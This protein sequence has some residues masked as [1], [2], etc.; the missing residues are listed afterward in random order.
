MAC[1]LNGSMHFYA[2]IGVGKKKKKNIERQ[3]Q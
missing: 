1:E 3:K 2:H